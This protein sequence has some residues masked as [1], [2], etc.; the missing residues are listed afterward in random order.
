MDALT[1]G[2][3]PLAVGFALHSLLR[4]AHKG[5][6]SWLVES[7]ANGIY[8]FGFVFMTPQLFINYKLKSVAHMPWRAMCYKFF[9]TFIDDVFSFLVEMP[10]SHRLAC[11]RDDVVFF[12]FLYQLYLYPTDKTRA[13]EFGIAYDDEGDAAVPVGEIT[14]R[15]AD[16]DEP[17]SADIKTTTGPCTSGVEAR[18]EAHIDS[19]E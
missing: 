16:A 18:N 7:L 13:N 6:Y 19:P 15:S 4:H 1:L 9:N 12:I 11:F 2:V 17:T 14:L 10:F 5:W 3:G 8:V